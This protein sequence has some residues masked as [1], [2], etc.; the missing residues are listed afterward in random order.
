MFR[1]ITIH[2]YMKQYD[3]MSI[4]Y[5]SDVTYPCGVH[6]VTVHRCN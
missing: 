4:A 6:I 3:Y 5:Y 1:T 2:F